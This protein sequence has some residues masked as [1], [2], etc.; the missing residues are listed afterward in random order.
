MEGVPEPLPRLRASDALGG[1][2]LGEDDPGREDVGADVE[3]EAASLLRGHVG[4]G[5]RDRAGAV[6][7]QTPRDAEV[8]HHHAAGGRDH[9]V[10]GLEVAV[11]E[12]R[13]VD[14]I[15]PGE[16]LRGDLARLLELERPALAEQVGQGGALE[17]LHGDQLEVLLGRQIEDPAN[18]RRDHLPGR[19]DFLAHQLRGLVVR[20][21]LRAQGLER[22]LDAQLEVE[23]APH[24]AHAT[25][26][27]QPQKAVTVSQDSTGAE[28]GS[29][30]RNRRGGRAREGGGKARE[31]VGILD[32]IERE[33]EEALRAQPA[34]RCVA[35]QGRAAL[36]TGIAMGHR[37]SV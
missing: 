27:E 1:Q 37:P 29:L 5:P 24:L 32:A 34:E 7:R 9:D 35:R 36:G 25:A 31:G 23:S 18:V 15:E 6:F 20:Q 30:L 11:D 4:R 10:L 26:A 3:G 8:H 2:H 22:H 19:A 33:P 14:R 21:Q 17:V 16:E 13:L 28:R 12:P